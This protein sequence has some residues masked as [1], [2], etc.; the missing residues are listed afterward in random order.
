MAHRLPSRANTFTDFYQDKPFWFRHTLGK[1]LHPSEHEWQQM[2]DALWEGDVL[3]DNWVEWMFQHQPGE[4]KKLFNQALAEG[5]DSIENPPPPL[6]ALFNQIDQDPPW[7]DRSLFKEALDITHTSGT[8]AQFVLR[9]MSLMGGYLL[10]DFNQALVLTGALRHSA[11]RRLADTGKWWFNVTTTGGMERYGVGFASTLQVRLIHALVRRNLATKPEWQTEDWGLPINQLD[12]MATCYAFSNIFLVGI[13]L[14][15]IPVSRDASKAVMHLWKYIGWL[16][17]IEAH[18]LADNEFQG[19]RTLFNATQMYSEPDW[20]SSALGHSLAEAT[21]EIRTPPGLDNFPL[22]Q[23]LMVEVFYNMHIS[24]SAMVLNRRQRVQLGLPARAF[25]WFP[26]LSAPPRLGKQLLGRAVPGLNERNVIAG[27]SSQ[28]R[29]MRFMY[30][31]KDASN[32]H[33]SQAA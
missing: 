12:L 9:D 5:I 21:R 32:A 4:A 20:T 25:P 10:S 30:K 26:L 6:E 24:T 15:G 19:A 13:R 18:W 8:A 11:N 14:F 33:P 7:L 16:M 3:M 28:Q 29:L 23:K 22:L 2:A 1:A 17:G 27:R 31:P